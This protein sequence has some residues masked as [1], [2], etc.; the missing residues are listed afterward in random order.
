MANNTALNLAAEKQLRRL[1][2][3]RVEERFACDDM[4]H[5]SI[6]SW[7]GNADL[8]DRWRLALHPSN[9]CLSNK[10]MKQVTPPLGSSEIVIRGL[11]ELEPYLN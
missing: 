9:T 8:E 3:A 1:F 7:H 5:H 11:F 4:T 10:T 6:G 2:Q